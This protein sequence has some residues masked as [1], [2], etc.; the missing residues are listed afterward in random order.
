[1]SD[2]V[3]KSNQNDHISLFTSK[4]V[5]EMSHSEKVE[6]LARFS[7]YMGAE[8]FDPA[9]FGKEPMTVTGVLLHP[10]SIRQEKQKIDRESG[11]IIVEEFY[12]DQT[13]TV[14]RLAD[15][16]YIGF[17]S[18]AAEQF[19]RNFLVPMFG[20]GDWT[21]PVKIQVKQLSKGNGRRTY[22]FVVVSE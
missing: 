5:S 14:F 22:N 17:V 2:I 13:R 12:V 3:L 21:E 9:E 19:A 15:G 7:A 1:M 6:T 4:P 16:R 18:I 8:T 11:E 20:L 10:V